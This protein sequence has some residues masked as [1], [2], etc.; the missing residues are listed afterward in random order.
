MASFIIA[1]C[2][3]ATTGGE[4]TGKRDARQ[5]QSEY[6]PSSA[7]STGDDPGLGRQLVNN[8][9]AGRSKQIVHLGR[10]LQE[11]AVAVASTEGI[12][13]GAA[14]SE[15]YRLLE[16]ESQKNSMLAARAI[17]LH[18]A[19]DPEAFTRI[20][21]EM[22]AGKLRRKFV[23]AFRGSNPPIELLNSIYTAMPDS[24]DRSNIG[25]IISTR[26]L[27]EDG[28]DAAI[29]AIGEV[30]HEDERRQNLLH[31]V[32]TMEDI[33]EIGRTQ[34]DELDIEKL[35]H[36]ADTENNAEALSI[37]RDLMGRKPS[38]PE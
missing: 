32:N 19:G 20:V 16:N 25:N 10:D 33:I 36:F 5:A 30:E 15:I 31:L 18:L 26:L 8:H 3:R 21:S 6:S 1:G 23:S 4:G 29:A 22:P 37:L 11:L 2:E 17:Y 24:E 12:T 14:L 27:V 28:A 34:I 35:A 7:S 9:I 38:N 13:E